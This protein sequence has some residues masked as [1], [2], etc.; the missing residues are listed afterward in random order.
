[1]SNRYRSMDAVLGCDRREFLQGVGA[2]TVLAGGALLGVGPVYAQ[3]EPKEKTGAQDRVRPPEPETNIGEFMKVPRAPGAIPG[4]FPGRVVEV[5]NVESLGGESLV[6]DEIDGDI[7]REMLAEGI[8]RLTGKDAGESFKLFFKEGDIVGLKVNPV[9][10]PLINTKLELV[11]AVIAWLEE[12]GLPRKNIVIWDRFESMLTAAG[13]TE[14]RFPGVRIEALQMM[15]ETGNSWRREDGKHISTEAF[16]MDAYYYAK[17]IEGKGVKGYQDDEFYL[18]QHV[19]NGEYSYFGKLI[20]KGLTKIINLPAF[21]NTGPGISMAT[22][23]LGYAAVCNTGRLH[24][25]LFFRVCTEVLAAPW[26]RDKLVLNILDALRGQ[27]DGG[28]DVNAQFVYPNHTLYF[29][30]DPFAIDMVGHLAITAKRKAMGVRVVDHPRYTDYL[31][32]GEK[33]EL[34]IADPKKIE[35]IK[36]SA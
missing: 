24:V 11:D 23:N 5:K 1:M 12:G 32:Q 21:K 6:A 14:D 7:V 13:Y 17:G 9:G 22:K 15:D 27:Y 31:H 28:P 33:L 19:F 2:C 25:P 36:V 26:I 35:H 18:N 16:D 4:P 30:T 29:A 8:L 34:G 20:T 10:P 3:D